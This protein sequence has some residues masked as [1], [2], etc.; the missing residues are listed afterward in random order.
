MSKV[1]LLLKRS[2]IKLKMLKLATEVN[3]L[4]NVFL[5]NQFNYVIHHH[6]DN[7]YNLNGRIGCCKLIEICDN[8]DL[9]TLTKA[10]EVLNNF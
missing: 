3:N 10:E 4:D 7:T 1:S 9:E 8:G 6:I 5:S 2:I